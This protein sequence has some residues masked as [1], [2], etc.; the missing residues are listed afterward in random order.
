MEDQTQLPLDQTPVMI[1][2][3][4]LQNN[5]YVISQITEVPAE[6]GDPN[7]K[8]TKPYRIVGEEL[9]PWMGD[10]TRQ[11]ELMIQSDKIVTLVDPNEKLFDM[12]S[13]LIK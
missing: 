2:V 5:D 13:E 11:T 3:L 4:L 12:Y 1:K 10:Y 8:L 7:C 6:F 9:Q